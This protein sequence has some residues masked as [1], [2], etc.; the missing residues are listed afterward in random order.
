MSVQVLYI[1]VLLVTFLY[2]VCS[3]ASKKGRK[4]GKGNK[5]FE[6]QVIYLFVLVIIELPFAIYWIHSKFLYLTNPPRYC[7]ILRSLYSDIT[8]TIFFSRG[9]VLSVVRLLETGYRREI[10]S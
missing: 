6:Q 2:T 9:L 3:L 1:S 5:M 8:H 4:I 10:V 7:T